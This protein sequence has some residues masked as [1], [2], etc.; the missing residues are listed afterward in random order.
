MTRFPYLLFYS[1]VLCGVFLTA[2]HSQDNSAK[3]QP[4]SAEIKSIIDTLE[5]QQTRERLIGQLKFMLQAQQELDSVKE[6]PTFEDTSVNLLKTLS[7]KIAEFVE[8]TVTA[9]T[10]VNELPN[11]A[12]WLETQVSNL[13]RRNIWLGLIRN[14]IGVIGSG[15]L[16]LFI[17]KRVLDRFFASSARHTAEGYALRITYL[18]VLLLLDLAPIFTFAVVAHIT[19]GLLQ[20]TE[21]IRLTAMAW[22]SATVIVRMVMAFNRF[23]FAPYFP[24]LRFVPA[25]NKLALNI[26]NWMRWFTATG[27]YGYFVLKTA[28]RLGMPLAFYETLMRLL[29]LLLS[30][31]LTIP[32]LQ[33]KR[34][35]AQKICGMDANKAMEPHPRHILRQLCAVWHLVAVLYVFILYGIWALNMTDGFIFI[36]KGTLFTFLILIVGNAIIWYVEQVFSHGYHVNEASS[37]LFPSLEQRFNRYLPILKAACKGLIFLII[38]LSVLQAWGVSTFAWIT[39]NLVITFSAKIAEIG[40]IILVTFL[41]WEV[42]TL[43]I[44]S[45]L[46]PAAGKPNSKQPSA[47]IRTLL[48]VAQNTLMIVLIVMSTLL[49]LSNIGVDI[50]P[51][52]AGAGVIGIAIGLG[53]QKL[54]HDIISG[55]SFL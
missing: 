36:L 18:F 17:T 10:M 53:G 35:V 12:D 5:N 32:I 15:Y 47:R 22:I 44:E 39:T 45:Y 23:I 3:T 29:G 16:A 26:D 19:L 14:L 34:R 49:V 37:H 33:N 21:Q 13:E 46:G 51:L 41:L 11:L 6:K 27:I 24:E 48:A 20:P 1:W 28:L 52:L 4:G 8:T 30:G 25:E 2:A 38:T 50:T 55:M 40:G 54:M 9:A 43:S 42:A 31:L 7:D